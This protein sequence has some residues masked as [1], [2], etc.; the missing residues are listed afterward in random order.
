MKEAFIDKIEEVRKDNN[1]LWMGIMR[2]AMNK[3][4]EATKALIA[5]IRKNDEKISQIMGM[6]ANGN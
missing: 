5:K 3:D 1:H 6:I 2:I 4:P